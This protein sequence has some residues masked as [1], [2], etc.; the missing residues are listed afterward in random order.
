MMILSGQGAASVAAIASIRK[1]YDV[2]IVRR[3]A[4][5]SGPKVRASAIQTRRSA[6]AF[7]RPP[8]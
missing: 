5:T 6:S 7:M 4:H 3:W 1:A 2:D 8:P